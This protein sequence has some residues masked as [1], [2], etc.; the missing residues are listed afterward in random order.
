MP[1]SRSGVRASP[2]HSAEANA[3][4][5]YPSYSIGYATLTGAFASA[6]SH[7]HRLAA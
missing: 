3:T 6:A 7:T 2:S 5:T 1:S 4:T